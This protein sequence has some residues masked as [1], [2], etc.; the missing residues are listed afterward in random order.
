MNAINETKGKFVVTDIR[1][2]LSK[3]KAVAGAS[4][5]FDNGKIRAVFHSFQ[6][7]A[8]TWSYT[9][10]VPSALRNVSGKDITNSI[11]LVL[12]LNE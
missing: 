4:F 9:G 8:G 6:N 3:N 5:L 12:A 10:L 1:S 11:N 2:N 7:P